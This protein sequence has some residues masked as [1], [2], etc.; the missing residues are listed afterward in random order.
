MREVAEEEDEEGGGG[1]SD[2]DDWAV[3]GGEQLKLRG[4]RR[5][6]P[7]ITGGRQGHDPL[8]PLLLWVDPI[9]SIG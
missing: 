4:S 3:G 6:N 1:S 8:G 5:V 2:D 9:R 7:R